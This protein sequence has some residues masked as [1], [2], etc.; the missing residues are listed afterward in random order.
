VGV[1]AGS[2]VDSIF[3]GSPVGAITRWNLPN[4]R[5][6]PPPRRRTPFPRSPAWERTEPPG[7]PPAPDRALTRLPVLSPYH[8]RVKMVR[9]GG[10]RSNTRDLFQRGYREKGYINLSTYLTQYKVGD[11][12]DIKVNAAV[13]KGMPHKVYHGRTGKVWNIT[14]RAIGVEV[15]KRVRGEIIAKRIHVRVEHVRPSRCREDFLARRAANDA[16][17][18]AAKKA[19]KAFSTKDVKRLPQ[20]PREG[21]TMTGIIGNM[22]TVTAVPYDIVRENAL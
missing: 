8:C 5:Y 1:P 13:H 3:L 9:S 10:K 12:V 17:R 14:K 19:G 22:T 16:V 15:N 7:T 18:V 4:E 2:A 6:P 11:Y 20:Q 21:F